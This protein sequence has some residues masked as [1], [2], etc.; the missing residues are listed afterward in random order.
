MFIRGRNTLS[1]I[2][3]PRTSFS[4]V[5]GD[6][7]SIARAEAA[8]LEH[9]TAFKF[10]VTRRLGREPTDAEL[11]RGRIELPDNR[12]PREREADDS[13]QVVKVAKPKGHK[14]DKVIS[15]L[16]YGSNDELA[17][18]QAEL[19]PQKRRLALA[20]AMRRRDLDDADAAAEAAERKAAHLESVAASVS[21]IEAV[22]QRLNWTPGATESDLVACDKALAQ[23][24]DPDACQVTAT[25]MVA[26]A[27]L[28]EL[29]INAAAVA[30]SQAALAAAQ[31]E[32]ARVASLEV[33]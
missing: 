31:A 29:N 11:Q 25:A 27:K 8:A 3:D 28:G 4:F 10:A 18:A 15:D 14:L 6:A 17:A 21:E 23:L 22:R 1:T 26:Q 33:A 12:T 2:V 5:P 30:T 16:N 19:D 20:K 7:A 13:W 32:V 9:A 24:R